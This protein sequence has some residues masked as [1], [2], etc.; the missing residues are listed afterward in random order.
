MDDELRVLQERISMLSTEELRRM[1][2]KDRREYRPEAIELARAELDARR[3]AEDGD[4]ADADDKGTAFNGN[5]SAGSV[6]PAVDHRLLRR[7]RG[8]AVR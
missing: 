2:G 4:E 5:G 7:R 3:A 6:V 1:V 8:R